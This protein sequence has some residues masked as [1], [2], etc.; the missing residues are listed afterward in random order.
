MIARLRGTV[1]GDAVD[2]LVIVTS[3]GVGYLVA[4]RPAGEARI[5][6]V[7]R[8][9][10]PPRARR[11]M[12]LYGFASPTSASSSRRC[13]ASPGSARRSRSRSCPARRPGSFAADRP[14][15]HR[16]VKGDPRHRQEDGAA[17][18]ARAEGEGRRRPRRGAGG[19]L[20][21]ARDA[22]VELGW[23]VVDAERA[24]AE[25]DEGCRPRS[26]CDAALRQA[27]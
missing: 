25:V 7:T 9:R 5:G 18:G 16:P 22:L 11:R 1:A 17:R 27:A 6:E 10:L 12:Q 26:G 14:R 8:V 21:V 13:S 4:P 3:N 2:G 24:L 19:W 23:S 20:A 15:R